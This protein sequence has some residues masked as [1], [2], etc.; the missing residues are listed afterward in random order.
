MEFDNK[1]ID[2]SIWFTTSDG[3]KV[4]KAEISASNYENRIRSENGISL[5]AYYSSNVYS[6]AALLNGSMGIYPTAYSALQP[7]SSRKIMS[8]TSNKRQ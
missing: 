7:I 5:R 4:R 6:D 3:K 1:T 8:V 2:Y